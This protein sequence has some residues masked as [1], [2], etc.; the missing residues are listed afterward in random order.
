MLV[1]LNA[2]HCPHCS[3]PLLERQLGVQFCVGLDVTVLCKDHFNNGCG[4]AFDIKIVEEPI[5]EEKSV[6]GFKGFFGYTKPTEVGKKL[7][8]QITKR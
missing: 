4:K 3:I 8:A 7:V 6:G 1:N 5:I 2:I